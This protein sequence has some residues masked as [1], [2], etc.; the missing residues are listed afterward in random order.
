M[1]I[2]DYAKCNVGWIYVS[3]INPDTLTFLEVEVMIN[4]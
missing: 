1:K 4:D 3:K 2:R